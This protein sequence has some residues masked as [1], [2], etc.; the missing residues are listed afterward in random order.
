MGSPD[1]IGH[2]TIRL[3]DVDL[4]WVVHGDHVSIWHHY[5]DM[6]PQNVGHT[7]VDTERKK[8]GGEGKGQLK[9]KRKGKEEE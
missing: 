1:V 2:V 4:V 6:V 5:G 9:G 7:D 8:E 3:P